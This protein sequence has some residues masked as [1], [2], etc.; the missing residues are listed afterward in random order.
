MSQHQQTATTPALVASL[1]V[2]CHSGKKGILSLTYT[3]FSDQFLKAPHSCVGEYVGPQ[4][5]NLLVPG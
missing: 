3:N 1:L 4:L 2:C 5:V